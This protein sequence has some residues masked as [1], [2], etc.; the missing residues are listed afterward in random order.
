MNS[1]SIAFAG[2]FAD[3]NFGDYGMLVNNLLDLRP[4][5]ATLFSYDGDFLETICRSYLSD[6]EV[7]IVEVELRPEAARRA[8]TG[9]VFTPL[10]LVGLVIN[11][12]RIREALESVDVLVVNGGGY[13][14]D[15]W[16]MPHRIERLM[17][18]LAPILIAD[19]MNMRIVFTGNTF[20]P[21]DASRELFASLLTGL[22][23][24]TFGCRDALSSPA[25]L[26]ALGIR[27]DQ[28][29]N[30]PD[31]LYLVNDALL[32]RP[33]TTLRPE[34]EY[35][36][37]E[38]YLPVEYLRNNRSHF[39]H[40]SSAMKE[41]H[42]LD[43]VFLPFHLDHGGVDQAE[44]LAGILPHFR[45]I[46]IRESGYLRLED[47]VDVIRNAKMVVSTR[48][49]ALV[50]A[51]GCETPIVNVLKDVLGDKRYYYN[52]SFGMI[53]RVLEGARLNVPYYL[54]SEFPAALGFIEQ[55]FEAILEHQNHNQR[56]FAPGN[57]DSLQTMRE[58][59]FQKIRG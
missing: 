55:N 19:Q 15:L 7:T 50:V 32:A 58:E 1:V 45:Y 51:L 8:Q 25:T 40:F 10:E 29:V 6:V 17:K 9:Y 37:M 48:Y 27:E 34:G 57:R 23:R 31:D 4:A 14:N 44:Y 33:P 46:D 59:L 3:V 43:I 54:Q 18:I 12:D 11:A 13:F 42:G 39:E 21:F 16:A 2:P 28:I 53:S 5:R 41:N 36:V 52:K 26:R 47:A 49:H 38:T 30:V 20:G 22:K 24:A 56:T 35:I